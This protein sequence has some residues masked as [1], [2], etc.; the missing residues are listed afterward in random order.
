MEREFKI[1]GRQVGGAA[2]C[3]VIA[4]AGANHN[5]D[6]S[7]AR[8]LI[9]VAVDA[10]AD[11]VKFQT[12][13]AET[14]YSKKTPRFSY[15]EGVS[16]KETWDLIKEIEL[17][18][19]WQGELAAYAA[20]RGIFFL[21]TPFDHR[22]V[23][24]LAALSVPAYKIASFEIVDL[25]LISHA[26]AKGRPMIIST[27]LASYE[28]IADAVETC[29]STGNSDH[30]LGIHMAAAAVALG[31]KVVEKHFTLDRSL[32]G[33]DHPFAVEPGQLKE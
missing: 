16:A 6:Q 10:G 33:P 30:S 7:M 4:E 17:P 19:E 12:Y 2:P 9:D 31:A 3:F 29:A 20:K 32:P 28:D 22:A 18:R 15:L 21:S 25:A 24:E 13:S 27:G 1:G 8:E 14:L 26:A 5:R 23:E 11:A